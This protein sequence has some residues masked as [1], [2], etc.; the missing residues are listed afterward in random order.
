MLF[1]I[2]K[3]QVGG[4]MT[5]IKEIFLLRDKKGIKLVG[6]NSNESEFFIEV[7]KHCSAFCK[8]FLGEVCGLNFEVIE[9]DK[10]NLII[11]IKGSSEEDLMRISLNNLNGIKPE[12]IIHMDYNEKLFPIKKEYDSKNKKATRILF[13]FLNGNLCFPGTTH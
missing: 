1:T 3:G 11:T 7:L 5:Y 6:K 13:E 2:I 4:F 10:L 8:K 12:T 9:S